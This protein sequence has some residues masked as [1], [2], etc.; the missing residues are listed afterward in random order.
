MSQVASQTVEAIGCT[1]QAQSLPVLRPCIGMDKVEITKIAHKI[2]T[3]ETSIL[4]YE[5]CCTI[6]SPAHPKT[7]PSLEEILK[8]EEEMPLL[9][10]LELQAAQDTYFEFK[11]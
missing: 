5:D 11:K 8:A 3:Y 6:F 9:L 2:G 4:P 7:K 1:D 10:D